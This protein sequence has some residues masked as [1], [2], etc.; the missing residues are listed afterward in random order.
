MTTKFRIVNDEIVRSGPKPTTLMGALTDSIEK[1]KFMARRKKPPENGALSCG[2]CMKYQTRDRWEWLCGDCPVKAFTGQEMC[3]GTPWKARPTQAQ[4][5]KER[6]FLIALRGHLEAQAKAERF[7]SGS[8][9]RPL[10]Y[11]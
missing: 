7:L 8:A 10:A 4:A 11:R 5:I 3:S 1:C 2:L 9:G 6:D